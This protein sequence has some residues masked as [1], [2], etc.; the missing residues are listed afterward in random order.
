MK[1]KHT[2]P[3]KQQRAD[4]SVETTSLSVPTDLLFNSQHYFRMRGAQPLKSAK[5]LSICSSVPMSDLH[6]PPGVVSAPHTCLNEIC[7]AYIVWLSIPWKRTLISAFTGNWLLLHQSLRSQRCSRRQTV[8]HLKTSRWYRFWDDTRKTLITQ[9]LCEFQTLLEGMAASEIHDK[10]T[11]KHSN[12]FI[13]L[14]N[15]AWP[16]VLLLYHPPKDAETLLQRC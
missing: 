2:V 1:K 12:V 14:W 13:P 16:H 11:L 3:A 8:Y 6:A 15:K 7:A 9:F 10:P 5:M 4:K